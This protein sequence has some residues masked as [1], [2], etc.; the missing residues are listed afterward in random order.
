MAKKR[1]LRKFFLILVVASLVG[2]FMLYM[3][4]L[5]QI[6]AS[7]SSLSSLK[8][9]AIVLP[10]PTYGQAAV[11]TTD[12]GVLATSNTAM[13][14]PIA[15]VTK[16]VTALAVLKQKPLPIGQQGPSITVTN[17]DVSV[18]HSYQSQGGSVVAVKV[19]QQISL[20]Q[21]LQALLIPSANNIADMLARWGFG[22]IDSYRD[23]ANQFV[24]E[25]GLKNT[26]IMDASG[27]SPQTTST[28]HDLILLGQAAMNEPVIAEVV[29]QTQASFPTVGSI[30]STNWL[31]GNDGI[32][33][34]KTGNTEEAGG[35]YLLAAKRIIEGQTITTLVATM[36]AP[37][38]SS[39]VN[40]AKA[41]LLASDKG[42]EAVTAL[43]AGQVV[44]SYVLPWG[45]EIEAVAKD[46]LSIL[47]WKGSSI[48]KTATLN[49]LSLSSDVG[50]VVGSIRAVNGG[51]AKSVPVILK[52]SVI[53][54]SLAWRIF[55]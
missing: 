15:S 10:W 45:G 31:L 18:F 34:L 27:F 50:A 9:E 53:P 1:L 11:G 21:A 38:L 29:G 40:D 3:R 17:D 7:Q 37:D 47:T 48:T 46:D 2:G 13:P 44:G 32:I 5:P 35:C 8:S 22:S 12:L 24:K 55:H 19:G 6:E 52:Q 4:P 41:L 30:K 42:F 36:G 54:P 14:A 23:F 33:G 25:L 16:L 39:A 49:P 20:Y 28:A 43:R 26:H 51:S